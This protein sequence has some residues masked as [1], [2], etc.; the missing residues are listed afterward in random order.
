M[1]VT[2]V[3]VAVQFIEK[4]LAWPNNQFPLTSSNSIANTCIHAMHPRG[5]GELTLWVSSLSLLW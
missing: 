4:Y 3:L 1:V 2:V 5:V